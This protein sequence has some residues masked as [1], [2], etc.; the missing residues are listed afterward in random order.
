MPMRVPLHIHCEYVCGERIFNTVIMISL[1]GEEVE[2]F[3][4]KFDKFAFTRMNGWT[5]ERLHIYT[6][7]LLAI[8]N[9][10]KANVLLAGICI[11]LACADDSEWH[12]MRPNE[13]NV[14]RPEDVFRSNW[15]CIAWTMPIKE[16]RFAFLHK[17]LYNLHKSELH[18]TRDLARWRSIRSANWKP[19]IVNNS[20]QVLCIRFYYNL[21]IA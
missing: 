5:V 7:P 1:I 18:S 21:C 14:F 6:E 13:T 8:K 4:L 11:S 2:H 17:L 9:A 12:A 10:L 16:W 3:E 15:D 19:S 20:T